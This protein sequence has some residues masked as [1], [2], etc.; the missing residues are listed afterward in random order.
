M[1]STLLSSKISIFFMMASFCSGLKTGMASAWCLTIDSSA[2][3]SVTCA[4]PSPKQSMVPVAAVPSITPSLKATVTSSLL[5]CVMEPIG[6]LISGRANDL[7][8]SVQPISTGSSSSKVS[9]FSR[10]SFQACQFTCAPLPGAFDPGPGRVFPQPRPL[11][12]GHALQFR[13]VF[14]AFSRT[15]PYVM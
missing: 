7:P 5:Y 8:N 2:P 12:S 3:G 9:K 14:L 6:P 10:M 1:A 13:I 4:S 15:S 11:H